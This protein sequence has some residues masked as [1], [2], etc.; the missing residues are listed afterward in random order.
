M[1]LFVSPL[2]AIDRAHDPTVIGSV[3]LRKGPR[4]FCP[5]RSDRCRVLMHT[6]RNSPL[7]QRY[8]RCNNA[9]SWLP[10][11]DQACHHVTCALIGTSRKLA[12]YS[13]ASSLAL[14][15]R[16]STNWWIERYPKGRSRT[17]Y[18]ECGCHLLDKQHYLFGRKTKIAHSSDRTLHV[19]CQSR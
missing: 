17:C 18:Q 4:R 16:L 12:A 13:Y 15:Q 6:C 1:S 3:A 2:S 8:E 14:E 5:H 11:L 9:L 19:L 10:W 7:W